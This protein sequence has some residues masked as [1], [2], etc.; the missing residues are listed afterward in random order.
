MPDERE[1]QTTNQDEVGAGEAASADSHGGAQ[2]GQALAGDSEHAT[3]VSANS[4]PRPPKGS[5][6]SRLSWASLVQ[7]TLALLVLVITAWYVWPWRGGQTPPTYLEPTATATITRVIVHRAPT[8]TPFVPTAT[9][10][11]VIH[12]VQPR[13]VL[14]IIAKEYGVTEQSIM[15]ANGLKSDLIIDGQELLIPSPQRTPIVVRVTT[16]SPTLTPTSGLRYAA[17]VL[18]W[19]A[20]GAEFQ[21][22]DAHIVLQWTSVAMLQLGEWYEVRLW[23][24]GEGT[25]DVQKYYTRANALQVPTDAFPGGPAHELR[26]SVALVYQ[27][28]RPTMLSPVSATRRFTWQ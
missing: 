23:S 8:S 28:R 14:G 18:L 9:P 1:S 21:G 17:P 24:A 20:D 10:E 7:A 27:G 3:I 2:T 12:V 11:P 25:D 13:D 6:L 16:P 15:E 22:W 4:S 19:P 5:A 26:W